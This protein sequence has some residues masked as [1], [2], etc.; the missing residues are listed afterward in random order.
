MIFRL[1]YMH[2]QV[3]MDKE[4]STTTEYHGLLD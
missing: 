2:L 3:N 4:N 1:Y